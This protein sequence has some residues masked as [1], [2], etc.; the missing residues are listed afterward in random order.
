MRKLWLL[1]LPLVLLLSACGSYDAYRE[2]TLQDLK[3][4]HI[5]NVE[6]ALED[7]LSKEE[8]ESALHS[9]DTKIVEER[10]KNGKDLEKLQKDLASATSEAVARAKGLK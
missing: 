6:R 9:Y 5:Q 8:Y 3:A 2:T 10:T 4:A 1:S 7:K